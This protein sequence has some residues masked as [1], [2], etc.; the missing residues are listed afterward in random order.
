MAKKW[1][2]ISVIIPTYNRPFVLR[3]VIDG[4]KKNLMY[5]GNIHYYIGVDG[6]IKHG[7]MFSGDGDITIIPGPN[8]GLGANLN[9]L[10]K[11]AGKYLL[12]LD[13]DHLLRQRLDLTPHVRKLK[14]DE[15]A[16]WIRLMGVG[17][18]DYIAALEEN[19][20]RVWWQ[21]PE[22]YIPSNRPHLKHRRFHK[23]FGLYPKSV[24]LG[25][26]EEIFCQRCKEKKGG[27]DVL[28][29]LDVMTESSWS[30]I[31]ESWQ[32]KGY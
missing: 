5:K 22:L 30:H 27:P 26:T 10:I 29:P 4:L 25:E 6:K 31:G 15:S 12:Q 3:R 19:Y 28:I 18:H 1:P 13:D 8:N 16:G 17:Y 11:N 24:L 21:S 20:W 9:R 23:H 14:R 2:T 32:I 7:K